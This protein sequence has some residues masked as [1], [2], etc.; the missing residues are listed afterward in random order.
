MVIKLNRKQLDY[1]NSNKPNTGFVA[2]LGS[3]KSYAATLKTII[4]KLQ[5]PTLTVAYYL[6]TYPL[7][8]DIAFSKFPEMLSEMGIEFVLN[9]TDKEILVKDH[10]KI[11]FRSMDNPHTIVGYEVFY[12]V[13]D[14][15]DILEATK[16][17][18]A[19]NK[20]LARN[21]QKHP[22]GEANALDIVGTPWRL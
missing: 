1:M 9:K 15:C 17:E 18:I 21:R 11:I 7:I 4:K 16:M 14:E 3:G 13:I 6:P 10:G 5:N 19:Y 2:G 12:T 22:K 8:R 20:I